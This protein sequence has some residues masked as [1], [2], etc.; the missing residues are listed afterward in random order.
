V[1]TDLLPDMGRAGWSILRGIWDGIAAELPWFWTQI[2]KFAL[3]I[4]TEVK[5][6]LGIH[7]PSSLFADTVGAMLPAGIWAGFEGGLPKLQD[8]LAAAMRSLTGSYD[9]AVNG[10]MGALAGAGG[11]SGASLPGMTTSTTHET[12]L[13]VGTLIADRHGLAELERT[14]KGIRMVED[15]RTQ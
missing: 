4:W 14:L 6:A 12:H 8:Q 2:K 1:L 15:A 5:K 9:V 10:R 7:S 3:N 13:H 11:Q